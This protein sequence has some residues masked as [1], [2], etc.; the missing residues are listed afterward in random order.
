MHPA[1]AAARGIADGDII[2]LFNGAAPA[3]RASTSPMT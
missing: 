3:W 2:R 1:D